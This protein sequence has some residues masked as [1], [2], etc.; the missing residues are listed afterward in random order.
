MPFLFIRFVYPPHKIDEVVQKN[1]EIKPNYPPNPSIGETV[2]S[3]ARGVVQG[4][5]SVSIY[6]V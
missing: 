3:A 1:L 2:I 4:I 6:E 5:E